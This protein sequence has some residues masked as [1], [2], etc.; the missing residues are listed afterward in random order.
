M[1]NPRKRV[2]SQCATGANV[3]MLCPP[4]RLS[5]RTA[6]CPH[7]LHSDWHNPFSRHDRRGRAP[8]HRVHR[9]YCY[10][11]TFPFVITR[12]KWGCGQRIVDGVSKTRVLMTKNG[13]PPKVERSYM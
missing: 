12:E 2:K 10:Y 8:I 11:Q 13:C 5:T 4:E 7:L 1:D 9:T 3:W 6:C